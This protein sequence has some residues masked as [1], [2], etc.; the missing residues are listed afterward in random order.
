MTL[1]QS[2]MM[3]PGLLMKLE[4]NNPGGSHKYRAARHIVESAIGSGR[5]VLGRTTVIEKTGGNF[6]FGLLAACQR[7]GVQVELAIGLGYSARKKELL[8]GLGAKLIG[9]DM[10][11]KGATPAEVVDHYLSH[12]DCG[13]KQYFYTDQ[14]SNALGLEA[15]QIETGRELADQIR[16]ISN[17]QNIL[18]IG[19]AGTGASFTGV[20]RALSGSGF[21]IQAHLVEPQE[22]DTRLGEFRDHRLEGMSVGVAPPFLDWRLVYSVQKVTIEEMIDTQRWAYAQRGIYIGNSSAGCLAVARRLHRKVDHRDTL[23]ACIAYDGGYW[24]SDI[25]ATFSNLAS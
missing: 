3:C 16:A 19:C 12:R 25:T 8:A 4:M 17:A 1:S 11:V 2:L 10:L 24:Y 22:C 14:F 5:I 23:V 7:Y 20:C 13:S 18:F 15:H 6:G 9:H 21:T